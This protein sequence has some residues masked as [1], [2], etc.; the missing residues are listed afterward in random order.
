MF[1]RG[2]F[3]ILTCVQLKAVRTDA[4]DLEIWVSGGLVLANVGNFDLS[5]V[6]AWVQNWNKFRNSRNRQDFN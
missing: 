4:T 1:I 6:A 5:E 2:K 3:F